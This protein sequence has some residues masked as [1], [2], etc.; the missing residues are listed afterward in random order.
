MDNQTDKTVQT[1]GPASPSR[2]GKSR[3][4]MAISRVFL[5]SIDGIRK[6]QDHRARKIVGK[7]HEVAASGRV[8]L[9]EDIKVKVEVE[10]NNEDLRVKVETN[11]NISMADESCIHLQD[12]EEPSGAE[13]D[14][15]C[16][17]LAA[18]KNPPVEDHEEIMVKVFTPSGQSPATAPAN[19]DCYTPHDV[20][21]SD[22]S[23]VT[24]VNA[25]SANILDNSTDSESS[26]VRKK[27]KKKKRSK[28]SFSQKD[29]TFK[30]PNRQASI[31]EPRSRKCRRRHSKPRDQ[32]TSPSEHSSSSRSSSRISKSCASWEDDESPHKLISSRH[33]WSGSSRSPSR[34][35]SRRDNRKHCRPEDSSRTSLRDKSESPNRDVKRRHRSRTPQ[36]IFNCKSDETSEERK[37]DTTCLQDDLKDG[38]LK[39]NKPKDTV[40]RGADHELLPPQCMPCDVVIQPL[41]PLTKL[42]SSEQYVDAL[43]SASED[44]MADNDHEISAIPNSFKRE[45]SNNSGSHN[46]ILKN[47][48]LYNSSHSQPSQDTRFSFS[49]SGHYNFNLPFA[50]SMPPPHHSFLQDFSTP[51]PSMRRGVFEWS[52]ANN[53]YTHAQSPPQ[54]YLHD[55][56]L[57][58][59]SPAVAP[60]SSAPVTEVDRK[61][62]CLQNLH[63]PPKPNFSGYQLIGDS[64]FLRFSQQLLN[65]NAI[66]AESLRFLGYCVSGQRIGDLLKRLKSGFYHLGKR[67]I[68]MIGTNDLLKSTPAQQ[69]MYELRKVVEHLKQSMTEKIVI[70]TLP[71]VPRLQNQTHHWQR[72]QSY[73]DYIKSL[74]DKEE[75]QEEELVA[76]FKADP[77]F[78]NG[79]FTCIEESEDNIWSISSDSDEDELVDTAM[80][81][82]VVINTC[83]PL[84]TAV[85]ICKLFVDRRIPKCRLDCFELTFSDNGRKDLIHLNKKGLTI[86]REELYK[87]I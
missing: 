2:G 72:L 3:P 6:E 58:P 69:M 53:L 64:M 34:E 54:L 25:V 9:A 28:T 83:R 59:N 20:E 79:C 73:N 10:S 33:S 55:Q 19:F 38:S 66:I 70:L 14:D 11:N 80:L 75:L 29:S 18:M 4:V 87:A 27:S 74:A 76:E 84:I 46:S 35:S 67:V 61:F 68:V 40:F 41:P 71:P 8:E 1:G 82:R 52:T 23:P 62:Q 43:K 60:I 22:E 37:V 63:T 31:A 16:E 86:V 26:A 56:R 44:E 85:D 13:G 57:V 7:S 17:H 81:T 32:S 65:E 45:T 39:S 15:D 77:P 5:T 36:R 24:P 12:R 49:P 47:N 30:V 51:P 21:S 42:S 50:H 48:P 78:C